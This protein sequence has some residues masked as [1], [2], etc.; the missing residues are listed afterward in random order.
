MVPEVVKMNWINSQRK[1][2]ELQTCSTYGSANT[3][4]YSERLIQKLSL[5][6]LW[7]KLFPL[8][9]SSLTN[10][11]DKHHWHWWWKLLSDYPRT[12]WSKIT[13]EKELTKPEICNH[14][15]GFALHSNKKRQFQYH[16]AKISQRRSQP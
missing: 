9:T 14:L 4:I 6:L 16:T 13:L 3:N 15:W 7:Q 5:N 11:I 1:K 2:W 12:P 8:T 10:I